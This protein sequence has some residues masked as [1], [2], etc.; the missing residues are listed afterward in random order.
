MLRAAE[1]HAR[2]GASWP[3]VLA[4]L[5]IPEER[6]RKK[7]GPC[8]AC[9]G[10][11]RFTFDNRTGRGDYF[12]RGCG[13]GSGFDLLMRVHRW[14]FAEARRQVLRAAGL[15]TAQQAAPAARRGPQG[16]PGGQ[17]AIRP[18][19]PS[20]RALRLRRELCHVADC[21]EALAYLGSRRLWPLP[22]GAVLRAHP[23]V[24][25]WHEGRHVGRY[26]ALV[27]ELRD[28][29]GS[30]ATLH[31][32]YLEGGRKLAEY[33]PRKL[34]SGLAGRE[35]CAVRLLP[36]SGAALGIAEGIETALSAALLD[37]LPVWAALN[38]SLLAKFQPPP[39]VERLVI[40][41]DRDMAG[42]AAAAR[43]MER[44]QG[45]VALELRTPAPPAKDWND[46][47]TASDPEAEC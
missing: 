8:P 28:G 23:S 5:G 9:G 24:E 4:S 31:V 29:E 10:R 19:Q 20:A 35:G 7:A 26:A 36:L 45:R 2:V 32:T 43:L 41:A 16:R 30:L 39:G 33:E 12:C 11:D 22:E 15:A 27:G 13:A 37:R 17:P 47:L 18:A 42:L 6:L 40:Y 1:I 46:V 3:A 34:L 14:D 44:L 38:T 21:A 25:Y